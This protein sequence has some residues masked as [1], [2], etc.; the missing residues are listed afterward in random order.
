M[1]HIDVKMFPGRDDSLKKSFADKVRKA[2]V[3]ALGC[4]ADDLSV[5]VEEVA[6]ENWNRDVADKIPEK[7]ILSGEM[8]R[9]K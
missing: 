5:S 3:E 4:P 8:Y 6:P 1:P 2:A 9:S 7:N